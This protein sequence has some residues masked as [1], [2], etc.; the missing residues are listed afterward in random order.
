M[1]TVARRPAPDR[2]LPPSP[3][4]NPL[5]KGQ[6]TGPTLN[7]FFLPTMR[8]SR[9]RSLIWELRHLF[10]VVT[11][12]LHAG[13]CGPRG[14]GQGYL[15][16]RSLKG[17]FEIS[18]D[19]GGAYRF[20]LCDGNR[21][22]LLVSWAYG[23]K[24]DCKR[25][26]ESVRRLAR[27]PDRLVK[28]QTPVGT[29]RFRL[30]TARGK[31][32]GES[33]V[34]KNKSLY[35]RAIQLVMDLAPGAEIV[36]E[37]ASKRVSRTKKRK[38]NDNAKKTEPPAEVAAE[39]RRAPQDYL[40]YAAPLDEEYTPES[41]PDHLDP[42]HPDAR[43][44]EPEYRLHRSK[45]LLIDGFFSAQE[46]DEFWD[47]VIRAATVASKV[48]DDGTQY[49]YRYQRVNIRLPNVDPKK[50]WGWVGSALYSDQQLLEGNVDRRR[51]WD[52]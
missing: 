12:D 35:K 19:E 40:I 41:D 42:D 28:Q 16:N 17:V 3:R 48:K 43:N 36:D 51:L 38:G 18:Q 21:T 20:C 37:T 50:H 45:D 25:A 47:S 13:V 22:V 10:F 6:A 8:F 9:L 4:I 31:A 5:P 49:E 29:H 26:I 30:L 27:E 7:I 1:P 33:P 46:R 14:G 52:E 23:A 44:P 34:Y 15:V 24:G 32:M 11:V 39:K 2:S